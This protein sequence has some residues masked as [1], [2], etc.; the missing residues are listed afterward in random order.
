MS[1][2]H[3][4]SNEPTGEFKPKTI[5]V[6]LAGREISVLTAGSMFSPDHVD[7]GTKVLLENLELA[8]TDGNIL[9]IGCGWGPITLA[10]A[11]A[12]PEATIWAIDVNERALEL[13]KRNAERLGLNNVRPATP[14]AVPSDLSFSGIWSNPPIRVGK[15]VLHG[16]MKTWLLR[17]IVGAD[18]YLVIQK[19]LGSD[20]LLKWLQETFDDFESTRLETAKSFRV[21]Q[22]TRER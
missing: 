3:Y 18:A 17:L 12:R 22:V 14:E 21:L 16:I 4:F 6:T 20:S 5:S 19:N 13:T 2:E 10:L 9:D 11:I 15:D 1:Q 8:P 7:T